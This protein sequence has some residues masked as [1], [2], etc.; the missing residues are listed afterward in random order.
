[1]SRTLGFGQAVN[2]ALRIA[3]GV[4]RGL[5]RAHERGVVHGDVKPG[6][7]LLGR[8]GSVKLADFGLARLLAEEGDESSESGGLAGTPDYMAPEVILGGHAT[9]ASDVWSLG[10][11]FHRLFSDRLPFASGHLP[12]LFHAIQNAPSE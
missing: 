9:V 12:T 1:M 7:V 4:A 11:L 8:Q 6:N 3:T 2:E 10:V 5:L